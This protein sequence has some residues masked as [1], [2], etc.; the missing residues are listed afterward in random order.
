MTVEEARGL[1]DPA[2]PYLNTA[3]FGL[4]PRPAWEALQAA[5]A[6]WHSGRTSWEHWG[7]STERARALW[8][9]LVGVPVER[10]AVGATVSE[11][12]GLV[13]AATRPGRVL[14]VENDFT[15]LLWPFLAQG[16]D[17]TSVPLDRLAARVDAGVDVVAVSAVQSVNGAVADLDELVAAAR[18]HG[19]LVV[20]DATQAVGW[21]PLDGSRLDAVAGAGYKWLCSPRGTAWLA[22]S[23][24]LLER[25]TPLHAGWWASETFR[26]YY[27][28]QLRLATE[29]RRLDTSPAWFSWVGCA[30]ALEVFAAVGVEAIHEHDVGLANR[31]RAG[32]EL[33]PSSSAIVSV[34]VAGADEKLARAGIRAATRAGSVRASFHLST[35]EADEDAALDA[36]AA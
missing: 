34:E 31:F 12:I 36:L 4:P 22:L 27:G 5:L 25:V 35:S 24:R 8:A 9:G 16:H 19:A 23:E 2:G 17:V 3:T 29:A 10:V 1:F 7:E 21:L 11:L 15:S 14:T 13:A 20:V 28:P 18:A 33:E 6:D 30:P 32:L 26:D